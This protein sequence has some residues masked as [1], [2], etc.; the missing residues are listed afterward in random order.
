MRV[1]GILLLTCALSFGSTN[2]TDVTITGT[3]YLTTNITYELLDAFV[4]RY[5]TPPAGT[6]SINTNAVVDVGALANKVANPSSSDPTRGLLELTKE[7]RKFTTIT[8]FTTSGD[9]GWIPN[10][11]T[12]I[13]AFIEVGRGPN[14]TGLVY[15]AAEFLVELGLTNGWRAATSYDSATND[16]R[17]FNDAMYDTTITNT[18]YY[19][20]AGEILGPWIVDDLQIALDGLR[21]YVDQKVYIQPAWGRAEMTNNWVGASSDS[22]LT[23]AEAKSDA[24]ASISTNTSTGG[25]Y[26]SDPYMY[27][28]GYV[29]AGYYHA[30]FNADFSALSYKSVFTVAELANT[31]MNELG[32]KIHIGAFAIMTDGSARVF[33]ANGFGLVEN[34][35]HL[36]DPIVVTAGNTNDLASV[37]LGAAIVPN[38]VS[39]SLVTNTAGIVY[40]GFKVEGQNDMVILEPEY[41]LTRSP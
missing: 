2:F 34:Q 40:Q 35:W 5:E 3:P 38:W 6:L 8:R 22:V 21:Y 12:N 18:S 15:T 24:E 10:I 36:L 19:A 31:N 25:S 7:I 13:P 27:T 9:I 41:S 16:W 37:A 32:G 29:S 28:F 11:Q 14:A 33:D 4:E 1:L 17:D 30:N 26:F 39:E 20:A 23:W